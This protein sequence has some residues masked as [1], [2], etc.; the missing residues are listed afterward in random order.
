[1]GGFRQPQTLHQG[2]AMRKIIMG[3]VAVLLIGVSSHAAW[4]ADT[5][6][7]AN[8]ATST[9]YELGVC[10]KVTNNHASGLSVMVPTGS[11]SE[12][13]SGGNSFIEHT[14]PGVS[15]AICTCSLP[16]GGTIND[17]SN[18]TAYQA[19]SVTCGNS[20]V[21]QTRTCTANV[22]SGSYTYSSCSVAN[23]S[24]TCGSWYYF[25]GYGY[26]Y[27]MGSCSGSQ[28]GTQ[29]VG[30]ENACTTFCQNNGATCCSLQMTAQSNTCWAFTGSV[31]ASTQSFAVNCGNPT[32][33]INEI[34]GSYTGGCPGGISNGASCSSP[35]T[36]CG[37]VH[38]GL[39]ACY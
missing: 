22:L 2:N 38:S 34:V 3:V 10:K 15:L 12:W 17:G 9:I 25:D 29:S 18:A 28:I 7:V 19:S 37:A 32:W 21:S 6:T 33:H 11:A 39:Y 5:Y 13:Y 20:C 31:I 24:T 27:N 30:N 16:W 36:Y 1:M 14:P 26:N 8:G 23:C 35:G 4:A